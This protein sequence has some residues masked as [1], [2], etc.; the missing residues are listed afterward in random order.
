MGVLASAPAVVVAATATPT[1]APDADTDPLQARRLTRIRTLV[2]YAGT[3]NACAIRIW[4]R[5]PVSRAW[6]R[7][8]STDDL[9]P[10][11]P[12]GAAPVNEARD[13]EVGAYQDIAFQVITITGGGSV[14]VRAQAVA[15]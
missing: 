3:V 9:D 5:D 1:G 11:S 13:W 14:E 6:Y 2:T 15:S 4:F 8:A 10:L 12:G 7:G